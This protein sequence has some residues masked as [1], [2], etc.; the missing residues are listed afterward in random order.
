ML[1]I[2]GVSS[3]WPFKQLAGFDMRN[4]EPGKRQED[5][6]RAEHRRTCLYRLA[7]P[8]AV[9]AAL[10][11]T[12]SHVQIINRISSGYPLWYWYISFC[13]LE[14]GNTTH[15]ALKPRFLVQAMVLYGFIQGG[16]FASFLP[17]A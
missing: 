8:Q 11:L 4:K 13:T 2:M 3:W 10:A 15:A 14:Y 12:N 7:I 17:P 16:L 6:S 9:L 1:V 5:V